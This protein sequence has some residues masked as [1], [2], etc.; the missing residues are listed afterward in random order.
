MG[1]IEGWGVVFE[2][3]DF[4]FGSQHPLIEE[5]FLVHIEVK[6]VDSDSICAV[7]ILVFWWD[8]DGGVGVH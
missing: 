3:E 8:F 7:G 2:E 1:R 4:G 5:V 6:N